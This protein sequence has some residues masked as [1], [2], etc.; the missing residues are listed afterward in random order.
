MDA[1]RVR[2]YN[3]GFGDAILI[4]VPD[5][6]LAGG[7]AEL[8]HILIDVGNSL[9]T[10]G[11]LDTIF[12]PVLK[13]V[14]HELAGKPLDLYI[15]THE[16]MDHVQGLQYYQTK[17]L[18]NGLVKDLLKPRSVWLTRSSHPNYYTPDTAEYHEKAKQRKEKEKTFLEDAERYFQ[19]APDKATD[20][21]QSLMAINN[22]RATADCVQLI[23]ELAPGNTHYV[24]R[25]LDLVGRHPFQEASFELWA[26]EEDTSVYY[27]PFQPVAFGAVAGTTPEAKPTLTSVVPPHGVDAGAFYNLVS[28]RRWGYSDNLLEID[29][30]NNNTSI[31]FCLN[32]RGWRL[33]FPGDAEERSWKEM[34]K[35][36]MLKPVDFFKI[37]HHGS[38]TGIPPEKQLDKILK[39]EDPASR[40]AVL[41]AYPDLDKQKK[42]EQAW[43]YTDVPR[44]EVLDEIALRA[45]LRQTIEVPGGGYIDYTFEG[46]TRNLTITTSR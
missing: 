22:P 30:A 15:M 9:G 4:S 45:G 40:Y 28:H 27:G 11:G 34:D 39:K 16:N 17:V 29:S 6:P 25:D 19:A 21:I 31:V 1:L 35:H 18:K 32:W 36:G 43:T 41:S 42:G 13:D 7:P 20:W 24:Y 33:L 23:R 2:I 14:L 10:E 5:A 38:I 12:E 44:Q 37:S 26:P 8:R 46:N 3:V